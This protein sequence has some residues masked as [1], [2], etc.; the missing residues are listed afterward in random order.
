[1]ELKDKIVLHTGSTG[2]L[3]VLFHMDYIKNKSS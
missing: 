1:M 2:G 3:I